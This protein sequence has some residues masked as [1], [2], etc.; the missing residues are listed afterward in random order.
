[1]DPIAAQVLAN[2]DRSTI[3]VGYLGVVF[4]TLIY[5][6]TCIQAV[7]YFR[8]SRSSTD[9]WFLRTF[10]A[11]IWF[12]DSLHQAMVIHCYYEYL[13]TSWGIPE[14]LLFIVWSLTGSLFVNSCVFILIRCFFLRRIWLLSH[15]AFLTIALGVLALA[16]FV[17]SLVYSGI[18]ARYSL[19]IEANTESEIVGKYTMS[20]EVATNVMY[21]TTLVFYLVGR[22][23]RSTES[24]ITRIIALVVSTSMLS[25]FIAIGDLVA[26]TVAP[27]KLYIIFFE[28]ILETVD[29]NAALTALASP[30]I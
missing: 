6:V 21:T 22:R 26:Y 14:R 11:A 18:V 16:R 23:G 3:G 9:P 19:L 30:R 20:L 4:S 28:F 13:I 17:M 1:M 7:Q 10:V 27:T 5:G 15:N 8:S 2:F 29:A 25:V 24:T 12:L